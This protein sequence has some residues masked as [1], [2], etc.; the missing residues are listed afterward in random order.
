M[1]YR[2]HIAYTNRKYCMYYYV[3]KVCAVHG[4]QISHG[5][6]MGDILTNVINL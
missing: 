6:S 1:V 3:K 5:Q 4:I 2:Y